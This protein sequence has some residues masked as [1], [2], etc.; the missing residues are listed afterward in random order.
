MPGANL[1]AAVGQ[2]GLTEL[3]QAPALPA[4]DDREGASRALAVAV[5]AQAA[6]MTRDLSAREMAA[7]DRSMAA[8]PGRAVQAMREELALGAPAG[9]VEPADAAAVAIFAS[10][11]EG[12]ALAAWWGGMA[13]HR[14]GVLRYRLA[15]AI[16]RMDERSAVAAAD[17][18][19]RLPSELARHLLIG[20]A[21]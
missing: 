10:T 14:I 19:N 2:H 7:L 15:R 8:L 1:P 4:I 20:L 11:A 18:F 16:N 5:D 17:W 12:K 9:R 21:A 3:R 13:P 6:A